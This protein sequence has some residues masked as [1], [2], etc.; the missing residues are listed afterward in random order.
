MNDKEERNKNNH[1]L[2][3]V[4]LWSGI[5]NSS[6]FHLFLFCFVVCHALPVV[7]TAGNNNGNHKNQQTNRMT[8]ICINE[9][10]FKRTWHEGGEE[11]DR[12]RRWER[13]KRENHAIQMRMVRM[14]S[15][16]QNGK[17]IVIVPDSKYSIWIAGYAALR[18]FSEKDNFSTHF[19][20]ERINK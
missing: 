18:C 5:S 10:L 17:Q 1:F 2:N 4:C 15:V 13:K 3:Y 12:E 8:L 9:Y 7:H 20:L 11:R 16:L 14:H 19:S 6:I